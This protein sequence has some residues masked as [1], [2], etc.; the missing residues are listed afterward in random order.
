VN[1]YCIELGFSCAIT[2]GQ[3]DQHVMDSINIEL[4]TSSDNTS[5]DVQVYKTTLDVAARVVE[6]KFYENLISKQR[7]EHIANGD[8]L[9]RKNRK[10][11]KSVPVS[12]EQHE[13]VLYFPPSAAPNEHV[14]GLNASGNNNNTND[15]EDE[16]NFE[17]CDKEAEKINSMTTSSLLEH[18]SEAQKA[19]AEGTLEADNGN[20]N[21][22]DEEEVWQE[23]EPQQQQPKDNTTSSA[24]KV[25]FNAGMCTS[26]S[27]LVTS[28]YY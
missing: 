19:L 18:I 27:V 17:M 13:F 11:F 6:P 2:N 20:N 21:N 5:S 7:H 16:T 28:N 26:N 24:V 9:G 8:T 14:E 4:Y 25:E 10:L 12:S 15:I 23:D 3:R 22:N 1:R